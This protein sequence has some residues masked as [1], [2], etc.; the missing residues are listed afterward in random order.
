MSD[1]KADFIVIGDYRS[2]DLRFLV[3][4]N[5]FLEKD[6]RAVRSPIMATPP[7]M[8]SRNPDVTDGLEAHGCVWLLFSAGGPSRI[9]EWF[10]LLQ[11]SVVEILD[12]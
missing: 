8:Y 12:R 6:P 3:E 2:I 1:Y 11:V 4:L 7:R 9:Y 5:R 10:P